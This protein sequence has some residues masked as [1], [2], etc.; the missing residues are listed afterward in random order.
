MRAWTHT[1]AGLPSQGGAWKFAKDIVMNRDV[2]LPDRCV[3]CN[4]PAGGYR[5]KRKL[6]WHTPW[7]Y[8]LLISPVIYII[9]AMVVS[10]RATIEIGLCPAHRQRRSMWI[11]IAW[12]CFGVGVGCFFLVGKFPIFALFGAILVLAALIISVT[13]PKVIQAQK[14]DDKQVWFRGA[15]NN[16]LDTFPHF[17]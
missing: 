1:R 2:D 13:V 5:L 10:K 3:K 14:T 12:A 9:V 6:S 7:I 8:A 4:N 17:R 15:G 16:Y 11:M